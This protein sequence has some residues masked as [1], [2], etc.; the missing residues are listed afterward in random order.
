MDIVTVSTPRILTRKFH[1]GLGLFAP[2]LST[3]RA[4]SAPHPQQTPAEQTYHHTEACKKMHDM[5][6]L[7]SWLHHQMQTGLEASQ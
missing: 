3:D 2:K 7:C 4:S 1:F 5:V 6:I